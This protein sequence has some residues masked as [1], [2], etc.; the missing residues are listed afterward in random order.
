[1]RQCSLPNPFV[2][3][4][5]IMPYFHTDLKQIVISNAWILLV[6]FHSIL[7]FYFYYLGS[8]I[9]ENIH[10]LYGDF[11]LTFCRHL[12]GSNE[13]KIS[14]LFCTE[15]LPFVVKNIVT[16]P[17]F[18]FFAVFHYFYDFLSTRKI[19]IYRPIVNPVA[20]FFSQN[21]LGYFFRLFIF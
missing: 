13:V 9:P 8:I 10:D 14:V 15:T 21:L 17:N 20:P 4:R 7:Y 2:L 18:F 1:M 11:V 3:F 6:V 19:K 12:W 5:N 16:S